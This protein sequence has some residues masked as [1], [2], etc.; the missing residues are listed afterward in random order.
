M[1]GGVWLSDGEWKSVS[2]LLPKQKQRK[3]RQGRP[4]RNPREVMSG[5]VHILFS[6]APWHLLPKSIRLIKPATGIF[7]RGQGQACSKKVLGRLSACY[8]GRDKTKRPAFIDGSFAQAKKKGNGVGKTKRGKGSKVM[9]ITAKGSR[10]LF[11]RV[12]SATPFETKL[13]APTIKHRFSRTRVGKLVGDRAC[14]SGPLDKQLKA[15]G[16]ELVV[17]HKRNR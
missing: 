11:L 12:F 5:I 13:V 8:N 4:R 16:V 9:A 6:G 2:D 10:P 17:P 15:K 3:D 1:R 7:G 14:D